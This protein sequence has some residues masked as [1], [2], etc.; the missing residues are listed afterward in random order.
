M[1]SYV[2]TI[3][4]LQESRSAAARCKKSM[5]EYNVQNFYGCTPKD[6]PAYQ[7]KHNGMSPDGFAQSTGK[8]YSF[9]ESAMAAFMSHWSLWKRCAE[10]NEEFQIFEHDAVCIAPIPE[11]IPYKYCIS[12]GQPSYGSYRSEAT[13]G[14]NPLFSKPYFPGAHAYRLKPKGAKL[15]IEK[16]K[17]CAEPTDIFL[18]LENFPWL[19]E[20]FPWPV[21]AD[22]SF[23]TIQRELG[24]KAKHNYIEEEFDIIQ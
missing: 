19:Q 6:N 12:L 7:L 23:T 18:R 24:C 2:I 21:M 4:H 3:E 22:D 15:L 17:E 5:P 9:E 14:V 10:G 11:F 8:E 13:L 16:A 20:Y 1:K